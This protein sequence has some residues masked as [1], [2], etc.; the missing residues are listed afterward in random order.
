M[1]TKLK[2]IDVRGTVPLIALGIGS[3]I[4]A[5]LQ[6]AWVVCAVILLVTLGY[7][8]A[9]GWLSAIRWRYWAELMAWAT[10]AGGADR[11]AVQAAQLASI[12]PPRGVANEHKA[13]V[14]AFNGITDG[15]EAVLTSER[16]ESQTQQFQDSWDDL[17]ES[18]TGNR[19]SLEDWAAA[20]SLYNE[21]RV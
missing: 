15:P 2:L 11:R 8:A 20:P 4:G 5:A 9:V 19:P 3:A 12:R 14:A 7:V 1:D 13:F 6:S 18:V 17:M 10:N 16:R 21:S